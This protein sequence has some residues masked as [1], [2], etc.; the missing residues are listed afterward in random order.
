[1]E[2]RLDW[3]TDLPPSWEDIVFWR[4]TGWKEDEDAVEARD[5]VA[6]MVAIIFCD[7]RSGYKGVQ[8]IPTSSMDLCRVRIQQLL[9]VFDAAA[10]ILS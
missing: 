3:R 6:S 8:A 10:A 1:M 7:R 5:G 2:Y 4:D 9:V